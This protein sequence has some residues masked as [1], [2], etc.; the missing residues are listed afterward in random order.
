M[1][2]VPNCCLAAPV[3]AYFLHLTCGPAEVEA[4]ASAASVSKVASLKTKVKK[5]VTSK[6]VATMIEQPAAALSTAAAAGAAQASS[7]AKFEKM[8]DAAMKVRSD[9]QLLWPI[10]CCVH[11]LISQHLNRTLP[12]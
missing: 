5:A 10:L 9:L 7:T 4:A 3:N 8:L 2:T 1:T 11:G 6:P 12:T